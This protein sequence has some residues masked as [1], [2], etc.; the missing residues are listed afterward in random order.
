MNELNS[1][2]K[3]W[4]N[5]IQYMVV[6]VPIRFVAVNAFGPQLCIINQYIKSLSFIL[7]HVQRCPPDLIPQGLP[8]STLSFFLQ[9]QL[10]SC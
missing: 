6:Y 9:T 7:S 10:I 2:I 8:R 1:Y 3:D 5:L 4:N